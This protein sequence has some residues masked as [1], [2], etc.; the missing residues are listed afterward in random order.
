[1]S[2]P[3]LVFSFYLATIKKADFPHERFG[4]GRL[5]LFPAAEGTQ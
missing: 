2:W 5:T 1:M 4:L 3:T